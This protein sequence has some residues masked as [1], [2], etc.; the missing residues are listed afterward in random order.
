V[1]AGLEELLFRGGLHSVFRRSMGQTQALW[2]T[3]ALF[4]VVH[5]L[6]PNPALR[7]E[8]VG[9][10]SGWK[11]IPESFH[12]FSDLGLVLGGWVT[13]LVFGWVLGMAVERTGSLWMSVGLHAGVVWVKLGFEKTAFC[14]GSLLPWMGTQ[15]PVGLA[16]VAVLLALGAIVAWIVPHRAAAEPG[17]TP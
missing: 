16:P 5:F 12:Q 3:S 9:W 6:K 11:L 1:V 4:S 8:A 15:L 14:K 13:L 2:T 17:K 7:I 10:T